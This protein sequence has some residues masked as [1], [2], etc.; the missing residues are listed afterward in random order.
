MFESS[1]ASLF[2]DY[3]RV[4]WKPGD[5][6]DVNGGRQA[7]SFLQECGRLRWAANGAYSPALRWPLLGSPVWSP[8]RVLPT[9]GFFVEGVLLHTR[10]VRDDLVERSLAPSGWQRASLIE[11]VDG[12]QLGSIWRHDDGS[13]FL[14]F[15]PAEA[16][17]NYWAE[18]YQGALMPGSRARARRSALRAYYRLRPLLPRGVQI[19][20]RQ[21]F[22]RAQSRSSFPRWPVETALQDLYRLLFDYLATIAGGPVPYISP[23]PSGYSWAFVLTHDVETSTGYDNL[24]VLKEVEMAAGYRSAWNFVP[25][26]YSVSDDLVEGLLEEGFEVGVHGLYHDGRDLASLALLR[27]R[28]PTIRRYAERWSAPGFRSPATLRVWDWMPLLGFDY[29]SSYPDT[30]PYEPQPGGCCSWWPFFNRDLVELPITVPQDHTLFV[31]LGHK[32]ESLWVEKI[33]H[34]RSAGGMALMI[35]HPDYL[36]HDG[37]ANAYENLLNRYQADATAWRALPRDVSAWWRRRAASRL[38]LTASG[39]QVVGPAAAEASVAFAQ[40]CR[41]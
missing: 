17:S 35:T 11:G 31:I 27:R 29:D 39:W 16:M 7:S 23:W 32:D 2:L 8:S 14:P 9:Q 24:S 10:L 5:T 36:S 12:G 37:L 13:V 4:P 38:E 25:K 6:G 20:L 40:P 28:L 19:R 22:T 15:D 41:C 30:D 21:R 33:D 18:T 34:L 1:H 26:R 3:F